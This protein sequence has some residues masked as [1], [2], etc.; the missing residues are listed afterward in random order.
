LMSPSEIKALRLSL[1]MTQIQFARLCAVHPIT[2]SKWERNLAWPC[3]E[4]NEFLET[5]A[6]A[7]M[8]TK[9]RVRTILAKRGLPSAWAVLLSKLL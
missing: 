7:S 2:V 1:D 3:V 8:S 6:S 4:F 5:F 9:R